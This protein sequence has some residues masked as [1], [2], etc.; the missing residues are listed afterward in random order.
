MSSPP[1]RVCIHCL[2][3]DQVE[4][5]SQSVQE[6][7]QGEGPYRAGWI[8]CMNCGATGPV[9]NVCDSFHKAWI[10]WNNRPKTNRP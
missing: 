6:G 8:E 1:H 5:F 4:M 3:R 9:V 2:S 7:L 10:A